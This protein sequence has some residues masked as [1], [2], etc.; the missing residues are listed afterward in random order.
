ML[1][2]SIVPS[3]QNQE[4]FLSIDASC[5]DMCCTVHQDSLCWFLQNNALSCSMSR[6]LPR[7]CKDLLEDFTTIS[8]RS[9]QGPVQDDAR[10]L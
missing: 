6:V 1:I 7:S 2:F 3:P 5:Q 8:T 4:D 10:T 9:P